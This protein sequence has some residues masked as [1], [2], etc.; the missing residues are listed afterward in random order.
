[1]VKEGKAAPEFVLPDANGRDVSLADFRGKDVV[2]YFY[3]QDDTPSCTK[4]ACAFRDAWSDL[5]RE[6][7]AVVGISPDP[8]ESH[9]AFASKYKLPFILLSDPDRKVLKKY[10]AWGKKLLYGNEVIGTI[11]STVWIG[12]DGK[13]AKHWARVP[14]SAKHASAVL[15]AIKASRKP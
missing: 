13:V 3:P 8:A 4:E 11:R 15:A 14:D 6:G 1:M 2:V 10:G 5:R 12:P 9:K 7:I